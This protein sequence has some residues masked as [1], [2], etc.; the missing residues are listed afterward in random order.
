MKIRTGFV[1][2]SSSSSFIILFKEDDANHCKETLM[3][4]KDY[5]SITSYDDYHKGKIE[6]IDVVNEMYKHFKLS[7]ID[8]LIKKIQ[9]DI[10][11]W[12]EEQKKDPDDEYAFDYMMEYYQKMNR[13]RDLKDSGFAH[14]FVIAFGDNDGD[15]SGGLMGNIMD[16]DGRHIVISKDDIF[17]YTE[18]NR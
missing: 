15:V 10:D 1:S 16:Y 9:R 18:Q 5:F 12:T 7:S 8:K 14:V 3:K 17:L 13:L 11:F 4:Y 6:G 2:N